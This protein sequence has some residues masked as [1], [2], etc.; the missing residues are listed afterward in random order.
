MAHRQERTVPIVQID[1]KRIHYWRGR[2]GSLDD[3]MTILF[4]HGAGGGQFVWSYQKNFF[5]KQFNPVI[6]ELPG[7][8]ESGG[9]GEA[10]VRSSV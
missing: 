2:K 6:I 8:G 7:H 3:R 1:G 4:V 5:E 10:D 9:D